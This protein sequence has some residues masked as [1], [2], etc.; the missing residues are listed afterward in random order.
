MNRFLTVVVASVFSPVLV[1]NASA[2]VINGDVADARV[3]NNFGPFSVDS[4]ASTTIAAGDQGFGNQLRHY[5]SVFQLPDVGAVADP[6]SA[7]TLS[8]YLNSAGGTSW[9]QLGFAGI[10]ARALPTV[11]ASDA[12]GGSNVNLSLTTTASAGLKS[13]S[14][15]SLLSFLNTQYASG[16]GANQY[17][18]FASRPTDVGDA[19][20]SFETADS[21]TPANR[22][23]LDVTVIPEPAS[24]GLLAASALFALRRRRH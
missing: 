24:L 7:A 21:L 22:P 23:T 9:V 6:F 5:V 2:A 1:S 11:L 12:S 18:F 8:F 15:A 13:T 20:W 19:L 10:S 4:V 3:F 16:A 14:A 17:V